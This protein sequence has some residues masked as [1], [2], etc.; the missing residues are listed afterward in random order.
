MASLNSWLLCLRGKSTLEYKIRSI[1]QRERIPRNS[2]ELEQGCL[3]FSN[4]YTEKSMEVQ[5]VELKLLYRDY[6]I[7]WLRPHNLTLAHRF[8]AYILVKNIS[9]HC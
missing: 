6:E 1:H 9:N 2:A 5:K 7:M 4:S 3:W 8:Q